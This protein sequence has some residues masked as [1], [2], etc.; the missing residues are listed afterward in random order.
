MLLE[1]KIVFYV[2]PKFINSNNKSNNFRSYFRTEQNCL[3][4]DV[5]MLKP[6]L[7]GD[8]DLSRYKLNK[9]CKDDTLLK[10]Y[11]NSDLFFHYT[12]KFDHLDVALM[13]NFSNDIKKRLQFILKKYET[14]LS[15]DFE[16]IVNDNF[17]EYKSFYKL[18]CVKRVKFDL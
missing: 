18:R 10:E 11:I 14:D 5:F 1:D 8:Y 13:N 9:I 15:I 7:I 6:L 17:I 2:V 12:Y 16:Q 4:K 3:A